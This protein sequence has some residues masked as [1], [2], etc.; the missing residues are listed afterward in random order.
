MA[1]QP[2][3]MAPTI[4]STTIMIRPSRDPVMMTGEEAGDRADDD[5][6]NECHIGNVHGNPSFFGSASREPADVG[7]VL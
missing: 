7:C 2:P 3:T 5:P 4:P 1:T 6:G